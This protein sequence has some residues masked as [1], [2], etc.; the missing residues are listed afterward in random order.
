M[1][2]VKLNVKALAAMKGWTVRELAEHADIGYNHLK[3][4]ACGRVAMTAKDVQKLSKA[5]GV[6]AENIAIE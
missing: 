1:E 3:F 5:T 2:N 6:P 4:V